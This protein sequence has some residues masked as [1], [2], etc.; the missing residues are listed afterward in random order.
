MVT[1]PVGCGKTTLLEGMLGELDLVPDGGSCTLN[2]SV[3]FAPQEPW[4]MAG[5]LQTNITFGAEVRGGNRTNTIYDVSDCLS[6][7]KTRTPPTCVK[8]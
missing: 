5:S 4:I 3:G 1:G 7:A 6:L 8:R 2:G